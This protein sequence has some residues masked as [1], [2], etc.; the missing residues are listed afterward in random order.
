M[1]QIEQERQERKKVT[2]Y[3]NQILFHCYFTL[4]YC[5]VK[6]C[7]KKGAVSYKKYMIQLH[8]QYEMQ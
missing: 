2:I 7:C 4:F 1:Q 3:S 8:S 6:G 5:N